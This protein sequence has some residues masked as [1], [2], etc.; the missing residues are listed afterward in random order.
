VLPA[1]DFQ[2]DAFK[3][4][5]G[6]RDEFVR[7]G[8]YRWSQYPNYFAEIAMWWTIF[9][10]A[11]FPHVFVSRPWIIAS[12][13]FVTLI[14]RWASGVLMLDRIHRERYGGRADC[15]EYRVTT[16]LLLPFMK[17]FCAK[18]APPTSAEQGLLAEEPGQASAGR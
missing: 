17:P 1:A 15:Q 7:T 6:N 5:P 10:W 18:R 9:F 12:P 14:M 8:L 11:G 3:R 16:P 13:L 2:K 4:Q